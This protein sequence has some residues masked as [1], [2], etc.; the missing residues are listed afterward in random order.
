MAIIEKEDERRLHEEV[1]RALAEF[2]VLTTPAY[3]KKTKLFKEY[4]KKQEHYNAFRSPEF[5]KELS[6]LV[7]DSNLKKEAYYVI[8]SYYHLLD[9]DRNKIIPEAQLLYDA[10]AR[11]VDMKAQKPAAAKLVPLAVLPAI[12]RALRGS[13]ML[14]ALFL[15]IMLIGAVIWMYISLSKKRS[16]VFAQ[17]ITLI[18]FNLVFFFT[19]ALDFWNPL[20]SNPDIILYI[21]V[22]TFLISVGW[23]IG[24]TF[25][26][27]IRKIKRALKK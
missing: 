16:H 20:V 24:L 3:C 11:K 18:V 25:Y 12:I 6:N 4:F 15:L 27:I 1:L 2:K 10:L 13:E 23:I 7:D 17:Y 5:I 19:Y 9:K 14:T 8:V 26:V 21:F 22:Y